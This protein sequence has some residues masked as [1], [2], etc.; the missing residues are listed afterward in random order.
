MLSTKQLIRQDLNLVTGGQRKWPIIG[1]ASGHDCTEML[2]SFF[3]RFTRTRPTVNDAFPVITKDMII[4]ACKRIAMTAFGVNLIKDL[5]A[6]KLAAL[7]SSEMPTAGAYIFGWGTDEEDSNEENAWNPDPASTQALTLTIEE[8]FHITV[9]WY[10]TRQDEGGL[11]FD[12]C[13]DTSL[14]LQNASLEAEALAVP[15]IVEGVIEVTPIFKQYPRL[16]IYARPFKVYREVPTV[17]TAG[18]VLDRGGFFDILFHRNKTTQEN[19][20]PIWKD[21]LSEV[22]A[23]YG[24]VPFINNLR[25]RDVN[26]ALISHAIVASQVSVPLFAGE[27]DDIVVIHR[28]EYEISEISKMRRSPDREGVL[29]INPGAAS[30]AS[31]PFTKSDGSVLYTELY[32]VDQEHLTRVRATY[33]LP[34]DTKGKPLGPID[35]PWMPVRLA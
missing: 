34:A 13:Q 2:L 23:E 32:P 17:S 10:D 22:N 1:L 29:T 12:T 7:A 28:Q 26:Q 16:G 33:G 11:A 19:D 8:F 5:S 27:L 35:D 30:G 24:G 21:K 25:V 6:W 20:S 18:I 4:K 9:P 31:V 3:A 14:L 15:G